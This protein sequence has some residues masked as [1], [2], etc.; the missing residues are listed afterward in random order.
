VLQ[1]DANIQNE[2]GLDALMVAARHGLTS[3]VEALLSTGADYKRSRP[4]GATCLMDAAAC[5]HEHT[6]QMLLNWSDKDSSGPID[7]DAADDEGSTA[8]MHAAKHGHENAMLPLLNGGAAVSRQDD[9]GRTALALAASSQVAMRMLSM[10]GSDTK[11]VPEHLREAL[12][13]SSD[14]V[15]AGEATAASAAAAKPVAP[16]KPKESATDARRKRATSRTIAQA[17]LL[18]AIHTFTATI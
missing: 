15:P 5:G 12:G 18:H 6:I 9:K 10:P 17:M 4:G 7:L 1:A 3:T 14:D 11:D 16:E 8:L 2:H 13:I